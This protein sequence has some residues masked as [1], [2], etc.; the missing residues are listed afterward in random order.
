MSDQTSEGASE[1]GGSSN[2]GAHRSEQEAPAS[3][4]ASSSANLFQEQDTS[5]SDLHRVEEPGF[6]SL[7]QE[8][9]ISQ[10]GLRSA[11]EA[12]S[13]YLLA[14]RGVSQP[15]LPDVEE[16]LSGPVALP[17]AT[18]VS[19]PLEEIETPSENERATTWD[20]TTLAAQTDTLI[21]T[22]IINQEVKTQLLEG[23]AVRKNNP[24]N[25][26][27]LQALAQARGEGNQFQ[28]RFLVLVQGESLWRNRVA[29]ALA[30]RLEWAVIAK[31]TQ[32]TAADE[33]GA[34]VINWAAGLRFLDSSLVVDGNLSRKNAQAIAKVFNLEVLIVTCNPYDTSVQVDNLLNTLDSVLDKAKKAELLL[35][36]AAI[37]KQSALTSLTDPHLELDTSLLIA[38]NEQINKQ[39]QERL[40]QTVIGRLEKKGP[41]STLSLKEY[42]LETGQV[43]DTGKLS[44]SALQTLYS[45]AETDDKTFAQVY[46]FE[47]LNDVYW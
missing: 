29:S 5:Q 39:V 23:N 27:E 40:V 18:E 33:T 28:T 15:A 30:E 24:A 25:L 44:S 6:I 34:L 32:R 10:P 3:A 7:F 41:K 31:D 19:N 8:R 21:E 22:V 12:G 17:G 37:V 1:T 16:S 14:E 45:N 47:N 4:E 2:T 46:W 42:L 9:D 35:N 43:D 38:V 20:P 13:A 26:R 11:A 36:Y